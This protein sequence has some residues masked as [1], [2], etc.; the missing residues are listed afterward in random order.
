MKPYVLLAAVVIGLF[1]PV[2]L[3]VEFGSHVEASYQAA[4]H[5][6][7]GGLIGVW[8]VTRLRFNVFDVVGSL[9]M[10]FAIPEH[11]WEIRTASTLTVIEIVC[12]VVGGAMKRGLL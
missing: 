9:L 10:A 12:A 3:F 7:V 2:L 5:L 8:A 11:R 4:A 1:R 6:L